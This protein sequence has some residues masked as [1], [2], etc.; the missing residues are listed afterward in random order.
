M[1]R[2]VL[3]REYRLGEWLRDAHLELDETKPL[4]FEELRPAG[5]YSTNPLDRDWEADAKNH[6]RIWKRFLLVFPIFKR[7]WPPP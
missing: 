3:A 7:S 6:I 1:E 4:G 5:P 2:I